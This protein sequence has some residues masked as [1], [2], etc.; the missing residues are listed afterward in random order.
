MARLCFSGF[1]A[2]MSLTA[3]DGNPD[4][5]ATGS[6]VSYDTTVPR[7]GVRCIKVDSGAGNTSG[8]IQLQ[9][10]VPAAFS[11]NRV[12]WHRYCVRF[13]NFP[14]AATPFAGIV[15]NMNNVTDGTDR[16]FRLSVDSSGFLGLGGG[17]PFTL[18]ST[19]SFQFSLN[20]WYRIEV[21]TTFTF[22]ASTSSQYSVDEIRVDGNTITWAALPRV[23]PFAAAS[24]TALLSTLGGWIAT[25]GANCVM[26]LD[27]FALND[28]SGANQNTWPG[29]GKI[30]LLL[31]ISDNTV[32][33]FTTGAGGTTS[34]FDAVNNRPPTGAADPGTATS[35]IRDATSSATDNYDANMTTYTNAGVGSIDQVRVVQWAINHSTASTT[36]I[37]SRSGRLAS[38]PVEGSDTT[39]TNPTA[40]AST[41][42]TG[43]VWGFG[44]MDYTPSVTFGTSPVLRVGK[45]TSSTRIVDVAFM[46]VQVEYRTGTPATPVVQPRM[47]GQAVM[48]GATR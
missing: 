34:L 39:M 12:I 21:Q 46:G 3:N 37:P 47:L 22:V 25:P 40:A 8:G 32:T 10:G 14:T 11:T 45:R 43:W 18:G 30:V 15:S 35:Q 44:P 28:D 20:T 33:G 26:Y 2:N 7:S 16:P 6:T 1:E 38:N 5:A 19:S 23:R 41:W 48:R 17:S 27:D 13:A 9:S 31:P 24:P 29:D 42:P 36:S 4:G